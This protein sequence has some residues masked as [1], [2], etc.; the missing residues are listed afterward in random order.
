MNSEMTVGSTNL[1]AIDFGAAYLAA[2]LDPTLVGT[3][4]VPGATAYTT[5]LLRPFKGHGAI[6]QVMQNFWRTYHGLQ[7]SLQRRFSQGISAGLNWNLTLS[8]KGNYTVQQRLQHASDGTISLRA[9][10]NEFNKLNEKLDTR[11]HIIRGNFVWDLPDLHAGSGLAAR[12]LQY[13]V[14]DWQ[15]SGIVNSQS[16]ALYSMGF[17]YVSGGGSVN[18]TGSPDYAARIVIVGDPGKGCLSNQYAQ[19]NTAAFAGP[20]Y[21]ST[22]M[23]SARNYMTGCWETLWDTAIARNIRLGGRRNLQ[24]RLELYNVFNT[25]IFTSRNTTVQY[26]SP[27]Q[28]TVLNA[29]YNADGTLNQ[30]RLKPNAAGFGAVNGAASPRT[31]QVQIRFS[32]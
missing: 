32:F 6:N 17:S 25:V 5:D 23:E 30:N 24:F 26:Q 1:N 18:L 20:A 16:G 15:L 14:N 11:R 10:Q 7:F 19:F 21:G 27:T 12:V 31:A 8:D 3:S 28:Q 13:A 2:N 4:T 22:G 9:D 29:Q